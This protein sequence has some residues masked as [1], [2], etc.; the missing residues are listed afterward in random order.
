VDRSHAE[1]NRLP[2]DDSWQPPYGGKGKP[3][4]GIHQFGSLGGGKVIAS[5]LQ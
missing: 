2:V 4:R 3:E 1:R 5:Q